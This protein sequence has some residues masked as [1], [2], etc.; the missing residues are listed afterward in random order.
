MVKYLWEMLQG[1]RGGA[2]FTGLPGSPGAL[3]QQEEASTGPDTASVLSHRQA[4]S[5]LSACLH[6]LICDMGTHNQSLG[7]TADTMGDAGQAAWE[8]AESSHRQERGG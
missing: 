5:H 4:P 2:F 7:C 1:S 3:A 6:F 8:E